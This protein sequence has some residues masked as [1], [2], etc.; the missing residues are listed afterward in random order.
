MLLLLNPLIK[1]FLQSLQHPPFTLRRT[2]TRQRCRENI[3]KIWM[4]NFPFWVIEEIV[5]YGS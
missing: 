4:R 1:K 2:Q 3:A 5:R